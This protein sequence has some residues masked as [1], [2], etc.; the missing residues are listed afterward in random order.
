MCDVLNTLQSQAFEINS[1]V[2]GFICENRDTLE[3]VGIL[4]N[5]SL[6]HVNLQDASDLLRFCYVNDEGCV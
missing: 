2:L 5:R 4:M 1:K 6:A 3:D